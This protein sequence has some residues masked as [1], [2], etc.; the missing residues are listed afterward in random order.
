MGNL[1]ID[2]YIITTPLIDI[3]YKLK[4]EFPKNKLR[5]IKVKSDE[6]VLTCVNDEH[7]AG[8]E[9]RPDAHINLKE[10]LENVPYGM[11]HCFGCGLA[12]DF[13][14][15][16]SHYLSSNYDYAKQWLISNFG[17]QT[18]EIH[19]TL[20]PELKFNQNIK[21]KTLDES[22]L[23]QYQ[24]WT[25]Y[26]AKRKLTRETCSNFKVR[27]DPKTRQVIFPVYDRFNNLRMLARRNIDTKVFYM[28]KDCEKEVYALNIIQK[29]NIKKCLITEGPF[30]CL[31]GWSHNIPTIATLG[32]ISNYQIEQINKSCIQCLYL[33][34]DNDV[35]GKHFTEIIKNRISN[36]IL[37]TEVNL[38]LDKKDLNDLSEENWN[39]LIKTYFPEEI[40]L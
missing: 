35:A 33:A 20:G 17:Q 14:G 4:A 37:I 29:N 12:T 31:A 27:Y 3:I 21:L 26:L 32:T 23:D 36:R 25:P 39:K 6:I 5:D 15:F 2:N 19:L 13:V 40:N 1:Q 38:P 24:S 7:K 34:F 8:Q 28:D 10:D 9:H 22:I 11:Y 16:V 30:D 18:S